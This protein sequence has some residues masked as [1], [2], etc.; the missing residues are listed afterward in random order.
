VTHAKGA[1]RLVEAWPG[2]VAHHPDLFLAVV[3]TGKG[4]WDDCED[5][6]VEYVRTH[7]LQTHV[8]LA[9]HSDR[10][11]DYLQ[12]ADLFVSPSDYEGFG[13]S[14]VEALA[15]GLP[16]VTTSVGVAEQIVRDGVNGF[17]CPPK[18]QQQL[19]EAMERAI[20]ARERWPQ[21]GQQARESVR[22]FDLERVVDQY[23]LLCRELR[24]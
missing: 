10:V 15:C 19:I 7:Q 12:A 24:G 18:Q 11:Q 2:L 8:A 13:L 21:I 16:I 5:Q 22:I 14:V 23:V 1:A 3:G 4:S 20:S 17:T 6:V 9:G